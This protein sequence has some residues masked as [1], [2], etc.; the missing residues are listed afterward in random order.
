VHAIF[1]RT[2]FSKCLQNLSI[3]R[4]I[5]INYVFRQLSSRGVRKSHLK[6]WLEVSFLTFLQ[7]ELCVGTVGISLRPA[8]LYKCSKYSAL[9]SEIFLDMWYI[10]GKATPP[11]A[12]FVSLALQVKKTVTSMPKGAS[13]QV[14]RKV[15]MPYVHWPTQLRVVFKRQS[16]IPPQL[17]L[18]NE[19]ELNNDGK[20]RARY[21][22]PENHASLKIPVHPQKPFR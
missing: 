9:R 20:E 6:T 5:E 7:H 2:K 1:L 16:R 15:K 10:F 3:C 14:S 17:Q 13:S 18:T 19:T 21:A 8:V 12:A 22:F 4:K 11:E